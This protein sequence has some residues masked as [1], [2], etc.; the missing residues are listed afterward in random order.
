M[1]CKPGI[2]T[3]SLGRS[4]A[5]HDLQHKLEIAKN[6]GFMGIELFF[7]DLEDHAK[8]MAGASPTTDLLAVA[9]QIRDWCDERQLEIIC[10]QPLMHFGGLINR[11]HQKESLTTVALWVEVA[12]A[13]GTSL[14][15]FPSS[16]LPTDRV[17]DDMAMIVQDFR[18]AADIGLK[19][20]PIIRFAFEALCWGTRVDSWEASWDIVAAVDRPNFGLCLDT[21]NIA[22]HIFADPIA[23]NGRTQNCHNEL[24]MS[25][26]RL[27][28]RV[29]SSKVFLVQV[30]DAEQL[31]MPLDKKHPFYHQDQPAKMSWSRNCRLFYGEVDFGGY[32]PIRSILETIILGLGYR[33][34]ISFE[35]F[36]RRLADKSFEVPKILAQRASRSWDK[37]VSDMTL[38]AAQ[39]YRYRKERSVL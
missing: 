24:E 11:Q 13:L 10:L 28:A 22:G 12:A 38:R 6:S 36:H 20:T 30:A 21:F 16:F 29:D 8:R 14:I 19:T 32:L 25:M 31:Q 39:D 33:G 35:V 17:T 1:E 3:M 18:D 9:S 15:L 37:I 34:W 27:L 7:E 4:F 2:C 26:K 23:S 5:G